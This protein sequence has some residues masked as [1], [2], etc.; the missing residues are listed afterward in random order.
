MQA[1]DDHKMKEAVSA[2]IKIAVFEAL[3][4][5]AVVAVY[6]KTNQL[7]HLISGIIGVFVISGPMFLR[8][9][10]AHAEALKAKPG[11]GGGK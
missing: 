3:L 1:S 5:L 8:W 7:V 10:K 6:L 11:E 4:F 9:F 2:L